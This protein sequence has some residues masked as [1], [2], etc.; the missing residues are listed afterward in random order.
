MM[1]VKATKTCNQQE[2]HKST[3]CKKNIIKTPCGVSFIMVN[4]LTISL[5]TNMKAKK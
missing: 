2:K 5:L 4:L 3:F 1:K